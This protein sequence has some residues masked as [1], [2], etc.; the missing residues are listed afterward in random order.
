MGIDLKNTHAA[1][2]HVLGETGLDPGDDRGTEIP[3]EPLPCEDVIHA[4]QAG[5][6]LVGVPHTQAHLSAGADLDGK[7]VGGLQVF[8]LAVGPPLDGHLVALVDKID[9][10]V[11]GGRT[12]EGQ[13]D[14]GGEQ[15]EV[16]AVQRIPPG[17]KQVQNTPILEKDGLLGLVDNQL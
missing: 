13:V 3:R 9:L 11:K 10:T 2:P 4:Y 15:G 8:H 14:Q 7:A 5:Q 1:L 12:S 16:I 17:S 6:Q